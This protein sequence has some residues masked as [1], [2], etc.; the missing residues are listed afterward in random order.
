MIRLLQIEWYKIRN[1]RFFWIGIGL[2]LILLVSTLSFFGKLSLFGT[3]QPPAEEDMDMMA[4]MIPANL[5]EAGFYAIP[6]I[7]QNISYLAGFFKFIPA[8]LLLFFISSEFEF[9][10]YR[11]NVI[12]GL[13]VNQFFISKF[14]TVVFFSLLALAALTLTGIALGYYHN[15]DTSALFE[16]GSF[17]FAYWAEVFFLL[18]LAFFFGILVRRSAIAIIILIIYYL[19]EPVLG[20]YLGEPIKEYLPTRPS[21]D[22]IE[23]PF[24][25]LFN[26]QSFLNIETVD[27]VD[28]KKFSLSLVYSAL[29]ALGGLLIL[30]KR[31]I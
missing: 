3:G 13:S 14:S 8:F 17:L 4:M 20:Y 11:Q 24:T 30:R 10:T 21:R 29:L 1:H 15:E 5:E 27:S 2:F 19:M 23:E 9:R 18:C 7:W 12:D 25:R 16:Q 26:I 28:W 6:Y 31:D 22:M